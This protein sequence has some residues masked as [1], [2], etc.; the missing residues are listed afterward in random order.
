MRP[1]GVTGH[2]ADEARSGASVTQP[3]DSSILHEIVRVVDSRR[4]V[5][6]KVVVKSREYLVTYLEDHQRRMEEALQRFDRDRLNMLY[7]Q[8][9]SKIKY[10]LLR[11]VPARAAAALAA[12]GVLKKRPAKAAAKKRPPAAAKRTTASAKKKP[13][14][15]KRKTGS[16]KRSAR[17]AK[18]QSV[19][20]RSAKGKQRPTRKKR[21]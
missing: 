11:R 15:A 18:R 7:G 10:Q 20:A 14:A 21:K 19:A 8:L 9:A 2:V 13:L 3:V 6:E 4:K 5:P 16:A 12:A 1:D 17:P